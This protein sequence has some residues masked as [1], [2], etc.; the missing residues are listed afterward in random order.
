MVHFSKLFLYKIQ[1]VNFPIV[2]YIFDLIHQTNQ[3]RNNNGSQA[4]LKKI[5]P[6]IN[7]F[8]D[9]KRKMTINLH[10]VKPRVAVICKTLPKTKPNLPQ[11][12]Q[13]ITKYKTIIP[14]VYSKGKIFLNHLSFSATFF[15]NCT[16]S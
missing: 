10:K 14:F 9:N 15:L 2:R 1:F 3:C 8:C 7:Y 13:A 5:Y 12:K 6:F 11:T 4:S 16:P